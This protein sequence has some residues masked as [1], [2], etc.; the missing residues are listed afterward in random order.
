MNAAPRASEST[1]KQSDTPKAEGA[2]VTQI[3]AHYEAPSLLNLAVVAFLIAILPSVVISFIFVMLDFHP[4]VTSDFLFVYLGIVT[5]VAVAAWNTFLGQGVEDKPLL[6]FISVLMVFAAIFGLIAALVGS[7]YSPIVLDVSVAFLLS[8]L[9]W[10]LAH[11][12]NVATRLPRT[13]V[14]GL[15]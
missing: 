7:G 10:I 4:V 6:F 8:G 11:T 14:P 15:K 12:F 5:G 3:L 1:E 2:K 13:T 9:F